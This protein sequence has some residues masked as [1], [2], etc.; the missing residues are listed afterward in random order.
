MGEG[1]GEVAEQLA[2]RANLLG[3]ELAGA[4][5]LALIAA[6]LAI[7]A[8]VGTDTPY[9]LLAAG[10][11][12]LGAGLGT[13]TTPATSSIT[14]T[15]PPSQQGVGSAL[16]DLSR[17]VGGA[18]GIAVIGSILTST[19]SSH[20]DLA[21]LSSQVAAKGQGVLRGGLT[22][23]A[24]DLRPSAH[25]VRQRDARR[26]AHGRR[27]RASGCDRRRPASRPPLPQQRIPG[28]RGQRRHPCRTLSLVTEIA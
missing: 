5:G 25:S 23:R 12:V 21:G 26:A 22:A 3:I 19:Y 27:R 24:A 11:A 8:Q 14:E 16:N 10:L 6:G 15:L 20:V 4:V 28:A 1:L 7:I 17:E 9:L 2:A 18:I 13:A